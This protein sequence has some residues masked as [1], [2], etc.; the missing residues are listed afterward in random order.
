LLC[1]NLFNKEDLT[2]RN[3]ETILGEVARGERWFVTDAVAIAASLALQDITTHINV[4]DNI[5][6]TLAKVRKE[7][8]DN[9]SKEVAKYKK[10]YDEQKNELKILAIQRDEYKLGL[11]ELNKTLENER[12]LRRQAQVKA[13]SLE[14]RLTIAEREL[15]YM[16]KVR[17]DVS[18]HLL[19]VANKLRVEAEQLKEVHNV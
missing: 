1:I 3:F 17:Q 8:A 15:E 5:E 14:D 7:L 13:E 2:M 6:K 4:R 19:E 9:T 11:D 10:L 12:E 18:G 16:H